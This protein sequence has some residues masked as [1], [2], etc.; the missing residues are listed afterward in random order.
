MDIWDLD[1]NLQCGNR[2]QYGC[3]AFSAGGSRAI[4]EDIARLKG[5]RVWQDSA[6]CPECA[7]PVRRTAAL[8]ILEQDA[9]PGIEF[10]SIPKARKARTSDRHTP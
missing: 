3:L 5:W 8:K 4:T 9:L 10:P 1:G 2:E 7:K 6:H